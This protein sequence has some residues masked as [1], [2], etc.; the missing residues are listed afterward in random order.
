MFADSNLCTGRRALCFLVMA[1]VVV[2]V[3]GGEF[4]LMQLTD[5]KLMGQACTGL[6]GCKNWTT[7][8]S[9]R[10][11]TSVRQAKL[12]ATRAALRM[13]RVETAARY[14]VSYLYQAFC[15]CASSAVGS[16]TSGCTSCCCCSSAAT[17]CS[18]PSSK[19]SNSCSSSV[20]SSSSS[21]S[22]VC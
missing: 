21:S 11:V 13:Q 2:C 9:A 10:G 7:C 3:G 14:F 16:R 15:R 4:K 20:A 1:V 22:P 17:C 19:S 18:C 6:N 5:K 12:A 8:K